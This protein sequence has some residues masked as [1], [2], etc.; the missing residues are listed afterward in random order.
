MRK[1]AALLTLLIL[2][3][4][5]CSEDPKGISSQDTEEQSES[6]LFSLLPSSKTNIN[7]NN[8]ITENLNTRENLF[9]FDYFYNGA[10]VGIADLN[11]DGLKDIFFTGNQVDNQLYLNKGQLEF[12]NISEQSKINEGKQWSNGITFVDINQDGNLDIY[13]SQGGPYSRERRKNLLYINQGDLSFIESAEEYGLADDGISTQSAF[14]DFDNDGDLDCI[15]MNENELYG[16]DPINFLELANTNEETKYYNSSHLYENRNGKFVDITKSAGILNPIFGLGLV[17]SDF[18]RDNYLDFYIASDYYLPDALYINNADGSFTNK[19]KEYTNQISFYGMGMDVADINNDNLE[20]IFVLDMASTDHIRSK[21]LMASMSTSRFDYLTNKAG[22]HYQYMYNSL[23]LNLGNGKYNNVAQM[24]GAAK[25]DW[26]WAVLMTDYDNDQD[27]DIFVTN[28]YRRYALDNDF[29]MKVFETKQRYNNQVPLDIKEGLYYEMPTEKLSNIMFEN[30]GFLS[31]H[32]SESE[33]GLEKPSYSNGAA[34]GDLDNDGDLDLVINNMDEIAFVY[35]NNANQIKSNNFLKVKLNGKTSEDFAK[36]KIVYNDSS[37]FVENK[38]VRGYMS[39]VDDD[40]LFGL[41]NHEVIDSLIVTWQSG[42]S[43]ILTKIPANNVV[44][45]K[46][47][48]ANLELQTHD[49]EYEF[50]K[51]NS[52]DIGLDYVHKEN[53][54]DDFAEEILLPYKQSSL[55]PFVTK[56]DINNDGKQDL[57]I[58]ASAGEIGQLYLNSGNGFV[59]QNSKFLEVDR[60]SEDMDA[61]FFDVDRDGDQ[62]LYVVS[63]GYEFNL[64]SNNYADRLYINNGQGNFTKR[65]LD[66]PNN[67]FSGK[68]VISIDYDKDGDEDL[69]VGNRIFPQSYPKHAPS[70]IYRNDNGVLTD[71]SREVAPDLETFGIINDIIQTDFNGDGW[72]DF[73]AVGEWTPIGF[74]Q[75]EN[76]NFTLVENSAKGMQGWWF[77]VNETDINNDGLPDYLIGNV[78]SNI[79]FKASSESPF[80]IYANDFDNNGTNDIVLSSEYKGEY[81]PVRGRECSSQQMP[82]LLDKFP[83]FDEFAN[84]TLVDIYG[85]DLEKAYYKSANTFKSVL[86]VNQGNGEFKKTELPKIYQSFPILSTI[87]TDVNNDGFEDAVIAGNIYQTEVETPRLDA[88]SGMIM[89]SNGKDGYSNTYPI[90]NNLN[91]EGDIKDIE[92]IEMQ[93]GNYLLALQNDGPVQLFSFR[94]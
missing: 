12:E 52:K 67:I 60:D 57:F 54:F 56:G 23:Q 13:V 40:V 41:G 82:F 63:G 53:Q 62:D 77:S 39:A 21:T 5:S 10:G 73:I 84:A 69:I 38:R 6:P 49:N 46:E 65:P 4:F 47:A 28:G 32:K 30:K 78:G 93:D 75:N 44:E 89:L 94:K 1:I 19:I 37:Q 36:V 16:F 86:L 25:T 70:T 27:K 87:F 64:G 90:S 31:F 66:L 14:F 18:N 42:K 58:G 55:G 20:D 43:Q 11:N 26:S 88:F 81:V 59:K 91:L 51:V 72:P 48:E 33:W 85:N 9:D 3:I 76:G 15:V 68:K 74:F 80:K 24:T 83:T 92:L 35:E 7:F 71:V 61:V 8:T 50:K 2:I 29:R 17:V 34:Y 79:K 45:L 22:F